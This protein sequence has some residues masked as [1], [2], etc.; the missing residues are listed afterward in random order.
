MRSADTTC[1]SGPRLSKFVFTSF[2]SLGNGNMSSSIAKSMEQSTKEDME[3][4]PCDKCR[5]HLTACNMANRGQ[6]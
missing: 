6:V 5:C 2:V 1:Q 4:N 3:N